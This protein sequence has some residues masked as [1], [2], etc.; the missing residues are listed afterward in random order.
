VVRVP[1]AVRRAL[2]PP[3][4]DLVAA[5]ACLVGGTLV[6]VADHA[7]AGVAGRG[8]DP[9]PLWARL[10]LLAVACA[11]QAL[12]RRAPVVALAVVTAA[13]ATDIVLGMRLPVLVLVLADVVYAATAFGARWLSRLLVRAVA[14]LTLAL[15]AVAWV[16]ADS[17][18]TALWLTAQLVV[19]LPTPVWW[20][21]GIRHHREL[22][23]AERDR[24]E[25]DRRAAVAAERARMARDLHDVVAG[26]LSAIALQSEAVLSGGNRPEDRTRERA[27]M[28][29]VRENSLQAL[30]EMRRMIDVL[31]ADDADAAPDDA[32]APR[33]AGMHRLVASARA[34]GLRVDVAGEPPAGLPAA[35]D[36]AAYRILQEA[37]T[38][39][40]AHAPRGEAR[41]T[42]VAAAG[43]LVL[44]VT[45]Q[46]PRTPVLATGRGARDAAQPPAAR[47]GAGLPSMRTRAAEVGGTLDAGPAGGRWRVRAELPA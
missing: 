21:A 10:A 1:R 17:W 8:P 34:A 14:L 32:G 40:V 33:L 42:V 44:E 12:R 38:N 30:A 9:V 41:V 13:L 6:Y 2:E 26:H 16:L 46:L 36:A 35:V 19:V 47:T 22:A 23:A 18:R 31:R 11:G 24:A 45:N 5:A 43:R 39:A 20:G 7:G 28:H 37:L 4:V 25:L 29:A 3:W 27:V 15:V